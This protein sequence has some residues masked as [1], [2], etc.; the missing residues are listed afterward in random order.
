MGRDEQVIIERL[1]G[2]IWLIKLKKRFSIR[3]NAP[4]FK[5]WLELLTMKL[6]TR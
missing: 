1:A 6:P 5:D 3:L 4:T 2:P